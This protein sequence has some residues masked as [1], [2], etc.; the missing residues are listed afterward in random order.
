MKFKIQNSKFKIIIISCLLLS[1]CQPS[2]ARNNKIDYGPIAGM[3]KAG[4]SHKAIEI[5]SQGNLVSLT[6][7]AGLKILVSEGGVSK[8]ARD[9]EATLNMILGDTLVEYD[10][11]SRIL[12]VTINFDDYLIEVPGNRLS[13]KMKE[14]WEGKISADGVTWRADGYTEATIDGLPDATGGQEETYLFRKY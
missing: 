9:G 14:V 12:R 1:G 2:N 8:L 4:G 13:G 3:W 6:N 7:T 11:D 10:A 5:D